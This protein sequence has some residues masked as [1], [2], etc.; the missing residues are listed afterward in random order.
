MPCRANVSRIDDAFFVSLRLSGCE[1]ET[2]SAITESSVPCWLK[3][4]GDG[5]PCCEKYSNQ[6][7]GRHLGMEH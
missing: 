2:E 6:Y 7:I 3:V 1:D 5:N 4:F